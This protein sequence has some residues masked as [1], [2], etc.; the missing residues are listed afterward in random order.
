[1]DFD[2]L[3][4]AAMEN[5][6][7]AHNE[8]KIHARLI[9]EA[10]NGPT[11]PDADEILCARGLP[12]LPDI[13]ANAGGITVSYF[14]WV[15][16]IENEQWDLDDVNSKLRQKMQRA[17]NAVVDRRSDLNASRPSQPVSGA[18]DEATLTDPD[19]VDLRTAALDGWAESPQVLVTETRTAVNRILI[20][21]E[22][23][24]TRE[25]GL[26]GR[27]WFRHQVYAPG[28]Y[29]GVWGQDPTGGPRGDRTA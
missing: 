8:A 27:P 29:T 2:I 24:L 1:M 13:L 22:R 20:R 23:A 10:A 9:C 5:Q 14:E 28:F 6:V 25:V 7:C 3:I 12:V 18:T 11:T 26:P 17:V 19:C 21:T 15:Q 4:P 16:N